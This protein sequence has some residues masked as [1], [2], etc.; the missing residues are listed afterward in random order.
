[1]Q[2][3]T[4]EGSKALV[5]NRWVCEDD[6]HLDCAL[7]GFLG[8]PEGSPEQQLLGSVVSETVEKQTVIDQI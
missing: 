1:M 5:D 8:R 6:D 4:K 7:L 2:K 3:S